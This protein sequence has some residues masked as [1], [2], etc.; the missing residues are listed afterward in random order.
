MVQVRYTGDALWERME[1]AVEKV[2]ERLRRVTQ[3]LN[4]AGVPYAV[5]GGLAVQA[6]VAQVDEAAV[7]N[8]RDVDLILN[9]GDLARAKTALK[10]AGFVFRRVARV[11]MFWMGPTPRPGTQ[12]TSCSRE[13]RCGKSIRSRA[14]HRPLRAARGSSPTAAGSAGANET[15]ILP[16]Q[17]PRASAD[18]LDVGLIDRSWLARFSPVLRERLAELI[19][20]PDG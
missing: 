17:G 15:N 13:R 16:R 7:R 20:N 10:A 2:K 14:E 4:A 9:R 11:D 8:T 1:R 6:W 18:M 19:D 12:C 3:S 5:V